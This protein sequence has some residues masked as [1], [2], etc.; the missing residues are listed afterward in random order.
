[1]A[2]LLAQFQQSCSCIASLENTSSKAMP[3]KNTPKKGESMPSKKLLTPDKTAELL[4]K[5]QHTGS[6]SCERES[7]TD[8]DRAGKHKEK[9]KKKKKKKEV[10]SEPTVATDSEVDET[11][12]QQEKHQWVR[13]WKRELQE[14]QVYRES[15]NIFLNAL[16]EQNGGSH[17][18]YLESHFH[19]TSLG[20]FFIQSIEE[21]RTELQ[22]QSQGIRHSAS[23]VCRRL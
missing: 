16:P 7:E 12:E 6:P 18:G 19:G 10:K 9:K 23:T 21:W 15:H 17:M 22:K 2:S 11:K 8:I 4:I 1:M 5:K 3:I 13:K 20:F 14:L